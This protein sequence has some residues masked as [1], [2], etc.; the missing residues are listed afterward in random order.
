M[1]NEVR[2]AEP[3]FTTSF[4][5]PMPGASRM[6]PETDVP[7]IIPKLEKLEKVETIDKKIVR[8]K[9]S[10]G[11]NDDYAK[12]AVKKEEIDFEEYFKK[13]KDNKFIV[14]FFTNIPKELK[15]RYNVKVNVAEIA[16]EVFEK[17]DKGELP[18]GSVI[19]LLADFGKTK[20]LDFSKFKDATDDDLEKEIK[21]IA[22]NNRGASMGALMGIVMAKFKGKVDGKKAMKLLQKYHV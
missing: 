19:D 12:I 4:L 20:K 13:Y 9:K 1:K 3:D 8:F 22:E 11:L 5:R 15:K 18:K 10:Y 2:K 17:V 14:D 21:I 6:Y 7:T 16:E